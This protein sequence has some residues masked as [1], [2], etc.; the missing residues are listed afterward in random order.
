[1][2][3]EFVIVIVVIIV[4]FYLINPVNVEDFEDRSFVTSAVDGRTYGILEAYNPAGGSTQDAANKLAEINDFLLSFIN[5]MH[6]KYIVERRGSKK[7][8]DFA[9]RLIKKYDPNVMVENRPDGIEDTS[10]VI[11]KGEVVSFCLREPES[12]YDRIHQMETLKFVALHELSHIGSAE[13]GHE[14][15]FW[16]DF[17][18][19]L[20]N[21]EESGLYTP[22]DFSKTPMQYCGMQVD[23][24][25]YY[26]DY[27]TIDY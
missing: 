20:H 19:V 9:K 16:T 5:F 6:T 27:Y 8:Q 26:D 10:F 2:E 17:K 11:N 15:L 24:N 3:R 14:D 12:G 4:Y 22:I 23:Y 7:S 1:M 25:P 18:F 13:Y 21:A